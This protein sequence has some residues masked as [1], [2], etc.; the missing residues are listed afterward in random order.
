MTISK[1]DENKTKKVRKALPKIK[2]LKN[3]VQH[4]SIGG[5]NGAAE[6]VSCDEQ[7]KTG[8]CPAD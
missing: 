4:G 5:A 8:D 7:C 2:T 3:T 6:Q 1:D